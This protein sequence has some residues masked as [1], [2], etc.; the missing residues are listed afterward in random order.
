MEKRYRYRPLIAWIC[1]SL[2]ILGEGWLTSSVQA[3]MVQTENDQSEYDQA[4]YDQAE[5]IR[6]IRLSNAEDTLPDT[7][8]LDELAVVT[9][10]QTAGKEG[11]AVVGDE[12]AEV[13]ME[14]GLTARSAVLMEASTGTVIYE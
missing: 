3:A 9:S 4:E 6:T 13:G 11:E 5:Y 2:I 1:V 12:V 10:V 7:A 14:F 8:E